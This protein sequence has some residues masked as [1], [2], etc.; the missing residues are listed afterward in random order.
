MSHSPVWHY[1]AKHM[2]LLDI[3]FAGEKYLDKSLVVS[4]VLVEAQVANILAKP[5][6]ITQFTHLKVKLK[7]L[8]SSQSLVSGEVIGY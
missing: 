6:V 2:E 1:I 3:L 5:L 7:V 4:Y 8:S